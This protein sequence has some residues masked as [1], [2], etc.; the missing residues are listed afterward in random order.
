MTLENSW[1]PDQYRRFASERSLPFYDLLDLVDPMETPS[2]ADLGCG[3]GELTA[4]AH[5]VLGAKT[6]KGFDI[7]TPM[8]ERARTLESPG[9]T[10]LRGSVEELIREGPYDIIIANASLQWIPDHSRV[11]GELRGALKAGGQIAIQVPHNAWHPS[12]VIA[13]EIATREPYSSAF[14]QGV[15]G[16]PV[17]ANVWEAPNYAVFLANL[18]AVSQRVRAEVYLHHLESPLELVEW[19]NGTSLNRFRAS[20]PPDLFEAYLREYRDEIVAQL[21][22]VGPYLYAFERILMWARFEP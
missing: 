9:L 14:G 17:A 18:G 7:S 19:M 11:L 22:D 3:S 13:H 4:H 10:F 1:N 12:H 2:V 8:L 15:P 21:G 6:T 20:L 16:D 5:R